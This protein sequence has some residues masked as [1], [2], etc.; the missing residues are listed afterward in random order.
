MEIKKMS[1][2]TTKE[3]SAASHFSSQQLLIVGNVFIPVVS[4]FYI[5]NGIEEKTWYDVELAGFNQLV[6]VRKEYLDMLPSL[7]ENWISGNSSLFNIREGKICV[8]KI[9]V[10]LLITQVFPSPTLW[11]CF[12]QSMRTILF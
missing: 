1:L 5:S 12:C 11:Q 10:K 2:F 3:T 8:I 7:G 6:A 4:S 9:T